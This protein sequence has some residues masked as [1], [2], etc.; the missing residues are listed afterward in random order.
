MKR[1]LCLP[2][3]FLIPAFA[4]PS[5]NLFARCSHNVAHRR[6]ASDGKS[7]SYPV[8]PDTA[9][10]TPLRISRSTS[11]KGSGF[12]AKWP[13]DTSGNVPIRFFPALPGAR[14]ARASPAHFR[15]IKLESA[16]DSDL[17]QPERST[18]I[19][20]SGKAN[21]K[22]NS[23][24]NE[25]FPE[26][27]Q[28]KPDADDTL[29]N[30]TTAYAPPRRA[31]EITFDKGIHNDEKSKS[32]SLLDELFPKTRL[33]KMRD[34]KTLGHIPVPRLHISTA[35]AGETRSPDPS[36]S[37]ED[38]YAPG[39]QSRKEDI[40]A[41]YEFNRQEFSVLMLKGASRNLSEDDFRR[42]IPRGKHIAEWPIGSDIQR[43]I[44]L[45]N[46][47][48]LERTGS[49]CIVFANKR[50]AMEYS[51]HAHKA[52][53]LSS[54]AAPTSLLGAIPAAPGCEEDGIDLYALRQSFTLAPDGND[55]SLEYLERPY[56]GHM[57]HLL[58]NGG[59]CPIVEHNA[60]APS[61][62][63]KLDSP[64]P[65]TKVLLTA[66]GGSTMAK[67][68]LIAAIRADG[69]ER[70]EL[71]NLKHW[72]YGIQRL[73]DVLYTAARNGYMR[74]DEVSLEQLEEQTYNRWIL[75]F[76][77][78]VSARQFVQTWHGRQLSPPEHHDKNYMH[79]D[80]VVTEVLW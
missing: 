1:S 75:D 54:M 27:A 62:S 14:Q 53:R 9:S 59:Y 31:P 76:E 10:Q 64:P 41:Q 51:A 48:S 28:N 50:A 78:P 26:V 18:E 4:T 32:T 17:K 70:G 55:F 40:R 67:R 47:W 42:I 79:P 33:S 57:Y 77:D 37:A 25:L 6:Y 29:R 36:I 52:A 46:T 58:A 34:L 2:P 21:S 5:Q 13:R 74:C 56:L 15:R 63:S 12:S 38:K 7:N 72:L 80:L 66:H 22:T 49:Y 8:K 60:A 71:W 73:Q 24:L 35:R 69:K 3:D 11:L 20:R 65:K 23:L 44:P 19:A 61:S 68:S 39:G 30:S 45:R 16:R 43:V